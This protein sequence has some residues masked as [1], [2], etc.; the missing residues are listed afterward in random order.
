MVIHEDKVVGSFLMSIFVKHYLSIKLLIC[1][2]FYLEP[3]FGLGKVV[4]GNEI[5]SGV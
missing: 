3:C 1:K 2:T 4:L 5:C